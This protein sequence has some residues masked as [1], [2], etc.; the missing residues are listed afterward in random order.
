VQDWGVI[1]FM[2][3]WL[4]GWTAALYFMRQEA[5]D[6]RG[7]FG[8]LAPL[9]VFLALFGWFAAFFFLLWSLAGREII[10]IEGNMLILKKSLFGQGKE[11]KFQ[12]SKI[13][14]PR[15]DPSGNLNP[16]KSRTI[17]PR[18][19]RQKKKGEIA[20]D[21]EQTTHQFGENL[22]PHAARRICELLG[23]YLPNQ[24]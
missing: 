19:S 2:G 17:Y 21:Y 23:Q 1:L 22:E 18:A 5:M 15:A 20:F 6:E 8:F 16:T 11:R 7:G 3:G 14:N 4:I 10:S 13:H 9:I 12:L 24:A